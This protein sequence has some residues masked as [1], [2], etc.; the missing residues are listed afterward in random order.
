MAAP[1]PAA[2]MKMNALIASARPRR[3]EGLIDKLRGTGTLE[4]DRGERLRDQMVRYEHAVKIGNE[5]AAAV[6]DHAIDTLLTEARNERQ[7]A[8]GQTPADPAPAIEPALVSFDG[9]VRRPAPRRRAPLS[10][11]D[12]MR[13]ELGARAEIRARHQDA[14]RAWRR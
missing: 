13:A 9:G 12:A 3:T 1:N 6:A 8:V 10:M 11:D 5:E 4:A 14:Q 2:S 7:Q